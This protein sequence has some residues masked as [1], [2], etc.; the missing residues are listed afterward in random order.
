MIISNLVG[1]LS[2]Q[3]FQY[4]SGR[5]TSLRCGQPLRLATD[6]FDGYTLHNGFELHRLFHIEVP[7]ATE[8]GVRQLLG[9]QASPATRARTRREAVRFL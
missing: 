4:A 9:W 1:G 6:H 3:M 5:S 7:L 8:G 2:N